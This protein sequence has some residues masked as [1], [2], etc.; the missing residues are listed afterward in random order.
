VRESEREG[1]RGRERE[2]ERKERKRER[3]KERKKESLHSPRLGKER[4]GEELGRSE[5][6]WRVGKEAGM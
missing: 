5:A 1:E 4:D 3:K 2:K 6:S